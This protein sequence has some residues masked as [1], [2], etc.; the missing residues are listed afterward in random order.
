MWEV[1]GGTVWE[2]GGGTVWEE[3]TKDQDPIAYGHAV[4]KIV[5]VTNTITCTLFCV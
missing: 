2:V 5:C 3:P 4:G 1:G